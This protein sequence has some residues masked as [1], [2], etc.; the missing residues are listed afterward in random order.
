MP[1]GS[2]DECVEIP[3]ARVEVAALDRAPRLDHND[4]IGILTL[5]AWAEKAGDQAVQSSVA[6][7]DQN[8][9]RVFVTSGSATS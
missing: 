7:L 8:L 6:S 5:E 4:L 1:R 2:R 9:E 3:P